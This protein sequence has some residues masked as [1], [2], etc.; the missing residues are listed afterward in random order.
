[1][2]SFNKRFQSGSGRGSAM[3]PASPIVAIAFLGGALGSCSAQETPST[4]AAAVEFQKLEPWLRFLRTRNAPDYAITIPNGIDEAT[5]VEIGGN[6]QTRP[7]ERGCAS[8]IP[9]CGRLGSPCPHTIVGRIHGGKRRS[10][11]HVGKELLLATPRTQRMW[12]LFPKKLK[13]ERD[14]N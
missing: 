4:R 2:I 11:L 3:S 10:A 5:Y 12:S 7:A 6:G 9:L 14:G 8:G 13:N 1:M